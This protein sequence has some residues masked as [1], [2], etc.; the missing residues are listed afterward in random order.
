MSDTG[1]PSTS[2]AVTDEASNAAIKKAERL[3]KLHDLHKKRVSIAGPQ[4]VVSI[5]AD[6]GLMIITM[7]QTEASKLNHQEVVN[8]YK[9]QQLPGNW[10]KKREW[11]DKKIQDEEDRDKAE[12]EGA[13]YDRLKMLEIQA[14]D[15][16]KWEKK[17][18]SKRNTDPGFSGFEAATARSYQ[19][20]VK[21][22]KHDREEYES[23]KE[24]LGEEAFY[25]GRDT[26]IQGTHKDSKEAI[27]RMVTDLKKKIEKRDK[28]S[29]RRRH[30]DDAD[31]DYINER[32]MKFNQKLERFY[33]QYTTEIKQNLE[34]GTAV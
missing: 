21:N 23:L 33:G 34:R 5:N 6:H 3:R 24:E 1:R 25:A 19:N 4:P 20:S 15:A 10:E 28:Y 7:K 26:I 2:K 12:T 13:D 22:L 29:R 14:D 30:D 9:R 11:A 18:M 17:Q 32:N 27:D 8:E 16:E 31:V